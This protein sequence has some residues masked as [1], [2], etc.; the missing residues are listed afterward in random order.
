M[1]V[2]ELMERVQ[3]LVR[4]EA[5]DFVDADEDLPP[6]LFMDTP[7]GVVEARL[8]HVW[9]MNELREFVCQV[10]LPEGIMN[11]KASR[12]VLSCGIWALPPGVEAP[13]EEAYC[14]GCGET[15]TRWLPIHEHPSRLEVHLLIEM[16][17]EG[18]VDWQIAYMGRD[19]LGQE[20]PTLSEWESRSDL[21]ELARQKLEAEGHHVWV[22][23]PG[24]AGPGAQV[25]APLVRALRK[26]HKRAE[27]QKGGKS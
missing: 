16:T 24:M 21:V 12:A 7:S 27:R 10:A 6:V 9:D 1:A 17:H 18:V 25:A 14:E 5:E 2:S 19:P 15:H 23:Y 13:C 26:A 11:F 22:E 20:P 3:R 4:E 8:A